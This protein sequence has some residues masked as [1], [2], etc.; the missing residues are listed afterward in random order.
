MHL[1]VAFQQL[2]RFLTRTPQATSLGDTQLQELKK[3]IATIEVGETRVGELKDLLRETI[4]RFAV[5]VNA[6]SHY[7]T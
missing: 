1:A 5:L 6:Y 2:L 3:E 7:L 4:A